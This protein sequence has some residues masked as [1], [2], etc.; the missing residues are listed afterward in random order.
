[1]KI[2]KKIKRTW[3]KSTYKIKQLNNKRWN[4]KKKQQKKRVK[5]TWSKLAYIIKQFN[6][7]GQNRIK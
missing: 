5:R 1:M 7:E 2:K 6:N 4:K 3:S